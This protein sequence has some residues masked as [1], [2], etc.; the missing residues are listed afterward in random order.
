M[1][2]I[3]LEHFLAVA[4]ERTF[5]RAAE[6]VFRT[7]PALSQSIK[8]LEE[9]VGA[10]LFAREMSGV[11]LTEAGKSFAVYAREILRMRDEA[12]RTLSGLQTLEGG[13]LSVA[14]H[15][16]VEVY[17]LP[18]PL[19]QFVQMF[20][21]VKLE[22]HRSQQADIP[23]KL[24]NREV[25]IGFMKEA[26]GF[27]DLLSVEV[28]TDQMTLIA[29]PQH[30]F[31]SR[32][33]SCL[34]ELERISLIVHHDCFASE[35]FVHQF[36]RRHSVHF[37]IVAECGSFENIKNFVRS[38]IGV[39]IVPRFTVL[40]ELQQNTLVEIR[41]PELNIPAHIVMTFRRDYIPETAR[42]LIEIMKKR[43][44]T[45]PSECVSLNRPGFE[46]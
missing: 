11:S 33:W 45:L 10:S 14:A 18:G 38:G 25:H 4:A 29:S 22:L 46:D 41:I 40:R 23:R 30:P 15:E 35:E 5:T 44:P 3:Q 28:F 8:R 39:A 27:Q 2:M 6:R 24:L 17:F 42:V 20:P 31:A 36:F 7:Q 37:R 34:R 16:D 26:P 9:Y 19:L 12:T 21:E 32:T 43:Q 1:D 13:T